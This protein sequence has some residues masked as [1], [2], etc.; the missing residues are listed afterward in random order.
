[1]EPTSASR[2]VVHRHVEV[3]LGN[4]T[5]GRSAGLRGFELAA[6]G[7]AAAETEDDVAQ[8]NAH[9]HFDQSGVFHAPGERED[10]GPFALFGADARHTTRHRCA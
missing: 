4:A 5:A 10:L 1:M 2:F 6:V 9:G 7:N 8:R 3:L